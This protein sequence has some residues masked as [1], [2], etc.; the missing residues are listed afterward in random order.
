[1]GGDELP[2][3]FLQQM[4]GLL[5]EA[6]NNFLHSYERP[7]SIGLRANL[8]KI[9]PQELRQRLPYR[10]EPAPWA[11]SGFSLAAQTDQIISPPPGKHPYHAAGLYYLQEPSAMAVA[12]LL[13]PQPG[14][15][16]LDLCAAPG[17]KATHLAALMGRQGLLVANETHTQ[18]AWEL[19]ENLERCGV[20]H[21]VTANETPQRLAAHFGA[22]FDRV[23]VDAPCSGEGMFRKSE[24]ARREWS[25]EFVQSCALRQ[26]AIL[27]EA[28]RLVRPGG[29]LVYST[30]TF[31]QYENETVIERFL[32]GNGEFGLDDGQPTTGHGLPAF[33]RLWPHQVEGEGHFAVRLRRSQA[34]PDEKRRAAPGRAMQGWFKAAAQTRPVWEAFCQENLAG[35]PLDQQPGSRLAQVGSYLYSLPPSLP[36]LEGLRLIHPGWWL[37]TIKEGRSLRQARFEPAHALALGLKIEAAQRRIDLQVEDPRVLAYLHGDVL[38]IGGEDGWLLVGVDGFPLGWGRRVQGRVKNFYPRGLR[39]F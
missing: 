6:Y 12:E 17:G 21:A 10:L 31:N 3:L 11:P 2:A 23:L 14:E 29:W 33:L 9:T 20:Q 37:G 4:Q 39:W 35:D 13:A 25:P 15:S 5:G 38:E 26:S 16:V 32:A 18:R 28:A 36:D 30:C 24:A 19:A 22:F 1:M 34:A 8:L 27:E 7:A